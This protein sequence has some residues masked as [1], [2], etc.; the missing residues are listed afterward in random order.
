MHGRIFENTLFSLVI[1]MFVGWTVMSV[2]NAA[3]SMTKA[4]TLSCTVAKLVTGMN[5][6]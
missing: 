6:S 5:R 3:S 2:A 4:P 1:A